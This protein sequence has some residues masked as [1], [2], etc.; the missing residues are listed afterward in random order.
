VGAGRLYFNGPIIPAPEF[1]PIFWGGFT[2]GEVAGMMSW[3]NGFTGFLSVQG[4]PIGQEP[5]VRQYG[6]YG[7]TVAPKLVA[8]LAAATIGFQELA[9]LLKTQWNASPPTI[10][11]QGANGLYVVFLGAIHRLDTSL[12]PLTSA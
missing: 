3:L 1:V 5:V 10:P 2:G 12:V 9:F 8:P 7:A 4:A 11:Q 6:V